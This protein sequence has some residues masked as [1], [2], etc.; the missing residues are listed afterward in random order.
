[1]T[2]NEPTSDTKPPS[3]STMRKTALVAGI[4]YLATFLSSIPAVFLQGAVFDNPT[5]ILGGGADTLVRFGALLDIVNGL[6][7]IGT[8]VALYSIV[9]RQH[10][11]LAIGFVASRVF[12]AATLFIG[13]VCVFAIVTLRQTSTADAD[14]ATL[15]TVQ[16]SFLAI[17]DWTFVLG[18]GVPALNAFLLGTLMYRSGLV[19]R[20]IPVLGLIG[21]P[22][23]TSWIVGY[24]FG[25]TDGA[26]AWHAIAVA[27]IFFWELSLGL[28]M[29]FKGFRKE[30]PLMIEA[31]AEAAS[32]DGDAIVSRSSIGVAS[33]AGAA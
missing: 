5:F 29:T 1:M 9:K 14:P 16:R 33:K 21:A 7:A 20:A 10:E 12:E 22:L 28:W 11:G 23:F 31:A 8:A 24:I 18:T 27:P 19:P 15:V 13:I 3:M 26:S 25:I 17:R 30:S 6:T 2:R 4:L 32:P